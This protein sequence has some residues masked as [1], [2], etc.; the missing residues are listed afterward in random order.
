MCTSGGHFVNCCEGQ[1]RSCCATRLQHCPSKQRW[2][3]TV[4][5]AQQPTPAAKQNTVRV[6]SCKRPATKARAAIQKVRRLQ[7]AVFLGSAETGKHVTAAAGGAAG[8]HGPFP[9]RCV[10][11]P[12]LG[13]ALGRVVPPS[14]VRW[15]SPSFFF[16][17]RRIVPRSTSF[18]F[19]A[20]RKEGSGSSGT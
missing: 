16:C 17:P 14:S 18:S 13:L 3:K 10:S 5:K 12:I 4:S 2:R 6:S 11:A 1:K 8:A 15:A 20:G 7:S 19:G 9:L